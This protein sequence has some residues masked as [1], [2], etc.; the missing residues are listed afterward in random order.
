MEI[1]TD[2]ESEHPK[3]PQKFYQVLYVQVIAAIV[4]G[5]AEFKF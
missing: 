5:I 2:T 4:L 1:H 3:K